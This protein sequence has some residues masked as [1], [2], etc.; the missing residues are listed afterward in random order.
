[1]RV[2]VDGDTG[3]GVSVDLGWEHIYVYVCAC[4]CVYEGPIFLEIQAW[5]GA[6]ELHHTDQTAIDN[7]PIEK[8]VDSELAS[9]HT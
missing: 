1:L 7:L 4:V 3:V 9:N 8:G 2:D 5:W 6:L